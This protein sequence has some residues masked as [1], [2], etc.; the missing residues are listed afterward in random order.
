MK[1]NGIKRGVAPVIITSLAVAAVPFLAT[2]AS[3]APGTRSLVA[4][5][6]DGAAFDLDEY[7]AGDLTVQ[8]TDSV[9]GPVD[10]D[11]AQD[12]Q[13]HWRITPFDTAVPAVRVPAIGEDTV[14]V[15]TTG[16]FEV[17]LPA[18]Q[19]PGSYALVAGLGPDGAS[20]NAITAKKLLTVRAGDAVVSFD[21]ESPLRTPAGA[22]RTVVGDLLLEDGTGLPG[23]VVDLTLTRGADGSDPLADAG[24]VPVPP[25]TALVTSRQVTTDADGAFD[26]VLSDPVE[27]GQGTELGGTIL[28]TTT[29]TPSASLAVD[30]V[31]LDPPAG[32]TAVVTDLGAG[33]P[34]ESLPGTVTVTAPDDSF[35]TDPVTPGVDGDGDALEDPVEGQ[36]VTLTL[37]HG[38]FTTGDD[39]LPSVV[40]APAHQLVDLGQTLTA[41]TDA[42]GQVSFQVTI[43][44]DAGFDHA[45]LVSATVTAT[46]GDV[47]GQESADWDSADPF[48]GQ[49]EIRL[50]PRSEQV[51]PVDPAVSGD[52]TYYEAAT[53]DQFGNPVSGKPVDL[54]YAGDLDDWDYSDDFTVSD[55]DTAGDI[56]VVSFEA[57]DIDVTGTWNAPTFRYTD[58]MGNAA[59]GTA[60]VTGTTTASFYDLDFADSRFSLASSATDTVQVGT[61]VTQTVTVRDQLGRPVR[62]Y[63]VQFFRFGPDPTSGEPQ[64]TRTTNG[65]G[66]ATYTF[67][68]STVGRA[69]ITAE[70]TDGTSNRTL[71]GG[72]AFGSSVEARLTAARTGRRADLLGIK[73][74]KR[75]AGAL[76]T[77]YR[78]INGTRQRIGGKARRVDATGSIGFKVKDK[79]GRR[80]TSYV[81]E[82]RST[83]TTVADTTNTVR[84]R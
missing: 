28:A 64:A 36:L 46:A 44:R 49:V 10:V 50:S 67:V 75:A 20:A 1:L 34:G 29:T 43:G 77:L 81:A 42:A 54:T 39:V 35:D 40:G 14:A 6:A 62:G 70:V 41:I 73:V 4:T 58:T 51:A 13:L 19:A 5:S 11:D 15:D 30:L 74:Q 22:D 53:L 32:S 72:V 68:G 69:R 55:F 60:D 26:A 48:D 3:A 59:P 12:L 65:L 66:Q 25:D 24:F 82:V 71:T 84:V 57:A 23:R 83:S 17:A 80:F 56:W 18:G 2:S 47:S 76:V 63:R 79:N 7:A 27:D 8:V 33:K 52:R 31:S 78:V 38:F 21:D 45:G 9:A 37:D 61:A 16:A